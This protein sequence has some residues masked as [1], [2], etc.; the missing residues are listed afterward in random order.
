VVATRL[1]RVTGDCFL[2]VRVPVRLAV[3]FRV[4]DRAVTFVELF[5]FGRVAVFAALLARVDERFDAAV[6]FR[7]A[8]LP[9]DFDAVAI[10]G[11]LGEGTRDPLRKIRARVECRRCLMNA[12]V[13]V[14]TA[15][16]DDV[17]RGI[18]L[19]LQNQRLLA[20]CNVCSRPARQDAPHTEA[21]ENAA[22]VIRASEKRAAP[23]EPT[24]TERRVPAVAN[25]ERRSRW[26]ASTY[27]AAKS[28][29]I[30]RHSGRRATEKAAD[31]AASLVVERPVWRL[32]TSRC[33]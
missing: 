4:A 29:E 22:V 25:D 19:M 9:D 30:R 6:V 21:S 28:R 11:I 26:F 24:K 18:R 10:D 23:C 13:S 8:F 12:I 1:I 33:G 14:M 27:V 15:T 17:G 20:D 7:R 16:K 5:R 2:A 3:D 32:R 31:R